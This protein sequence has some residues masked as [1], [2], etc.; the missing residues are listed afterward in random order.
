VQLLGDVP[1]LH[2]QQRDAL[3]RR[4]KGKAVGDLD[5]DELRELCAVMQRSINGS[6]KTLMD[7]ALK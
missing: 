5:D 2:I 6:R 3:Q 7:R 1:L 4:Y